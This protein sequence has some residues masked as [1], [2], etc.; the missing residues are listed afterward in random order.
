MNAAQE[1]ADIKRRWHETLDKFNEDQIPSEVV[2][3]WAALNV[4]RLIALAE[5]RAQ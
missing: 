4:D 1:I 3:L 5:S 2:A